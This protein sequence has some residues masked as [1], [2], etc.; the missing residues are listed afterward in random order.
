[1]TRTMSKRRAIIT[2]VVG[3]AVLLASVDWAMAIVAYKDNFDVRFESDEALMLHP[4]DFE[5]LQRTRYQFASD[6]GQLLTGYLYHAGDGQR[7]MVVMAHGLGGGGHNSYLDCIN[8]FAQH[9]YYVFA[10]DATG[11]DESEGDSVRGIPQGVIDLDHALTFVE[12]SGDFPDL[13]IV[14]FGHSWGGYSVCSV[15]TYHPEVRAV[16]EC[17]GFNSSADLFEAQGKKQIGAAIYLMMP[18]VR[19]DERLDF[20]AYATNTALDG[21][22]ASDAAVMVVQGSED[23][24]VPTAYGYDLFADAYADD[25]RFRF[26]LLEGKGHNF[27]NVSSPAMDEFVRRYDAWLAGLS[28][29]YES[30]ANRKRFHEERTAFIRE[31][32]DRAAWCNRLDTELFDSFVAF[33]DEHLER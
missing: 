6:Q 28:Y 27:F 4:D 12:E 13:P 18:F 5:G 2:I 7:G 8:H 33:F 23:V 21:F 17:A 24:V 22:A 32:L 9:G 26:V 30:E 14:L 10:Y 3:L 1:M 25:P 29:D 11:N 20:G 16:V 31:N 19:L 15:L